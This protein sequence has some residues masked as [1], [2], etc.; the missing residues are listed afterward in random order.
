MALLSSFLDCGENAVVVVVERRGGKD[1]G[2]TVTGTAMVVLD[3][4]ETKTVLL[5]IQCEG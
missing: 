2:G 1:E 4:A 3:K 5:E